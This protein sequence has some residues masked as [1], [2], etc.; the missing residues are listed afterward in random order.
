MAVAAAI[1]GVVAVGGEIYQQED[2]SGKDKKSAKA[3][4][5]MQLLQQAAEKKRIQAENAKP[6]VGMYVLI[7]VGI[8]GVLGL[9]YMLTKP[10]K[11]PVAAV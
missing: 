7:G 4:L 3:Q 11:V 10:V 9:V 1:L 6:K 5:T 2:K 8:I